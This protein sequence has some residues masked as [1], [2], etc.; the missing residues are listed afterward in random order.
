MSH[1][2]LLGHSGLKQ[3]MRKRRGIGEEENEL[4]EVPVVYWEVFAP[5]KH[6]YYQTRNWKKLSPNLVYVQ[7][8]TISLLL[9]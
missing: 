4:E 6:N 9:A 5:R 7:V 2:E 3:N 1:N 8:K